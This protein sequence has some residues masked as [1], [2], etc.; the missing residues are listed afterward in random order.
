MYKEIDRCRI[1]GNPKLRTVLNL[2]VQKLTGVFPEPGQPVDEAPLELVKCDGED[3][4]GLVQLRHS[5][6][7]SQMYGMNYGYRSG[8]N[9]SMVRHLTHITDY[10]KKKVHLIN[11]DIVVDIGSNDGTLLGTYASA[12]GPK[13]R[14]IGIDPTSV[15]FKQYYQPDIQIVEDFFSADN[16]R[17]VCGEAKAKVITSIA[18]FYDLESPVDFARQ[19]SECLAY[20]GIWVFEQSYM[21]YMIQAKSFDTVCQEHLEYYDMKQI[22]W[23]VDAA[24]MKI[25]DVDFNNVNGGSFRITAAKKDSLYEVSPKVIQASVAEDVGGYNSFEIFDTFKDEIDE[26]RK[27]C[28]SFFEQCAR[29]GKKVIGYGASTKGNVLLQ[30]FGITTKELP[31]IAEVNE[32]KFGH[33]TPGTNI[34]II[35]E[36]EARAMNPDYLF[37]LPWHF[38]N[39]ILEK[40]SDYIKSSGCRFVFPLPQFSIEDIG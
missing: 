26:C 25:I 34:P 32:D 12:D 33:V 4:C 7:S 9:A 1:C 39:N 17:K 11:G 6:D 18:M 14:R 27:Q 38:K 31:Y 3:C 8:L 35:S 36:D 24:G 37:V 10:V 22:E 30:Y 16:F 29:E 21:P 40:E 5:C 19:I 23:I 15:K 13:L 28:M 20:D 2:G